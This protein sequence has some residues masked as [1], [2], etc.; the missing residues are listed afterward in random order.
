[1]AD[2]YS[3][4]SECLDMPCIFNEYA[5]VLLP[6]IDPYRT[7]TIHSKENFVLIGLIS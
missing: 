5:L 6:L 4:P 3:M 1:M 2:H 7:D